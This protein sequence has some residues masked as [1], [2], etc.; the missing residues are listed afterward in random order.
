MAATALQIS[1]VSATG[2]PKMVH[3]KLPK[4]VLSR[5]TVPSPS[6]SVI[7]SIHTFGSPKLDQLIGQN[8]TPLDV[9]NEVISAVKTPQF[10]DSTAMYQPTRIKTVWERLNS[11]ELYELVKHRLTIT[12]D[13]STL[14]GLVQNYQSPTVINPRA[15]FLSPNSTYSLPGVPGIPGMLGSPQQLSPKSPRISNKISVTIHDTVSDVGTQHYLDDF[16]SS[17]LRPPLSVLNSQ[18]GG[19]LTHNAVSSY[20]GGQNKTHTLLGSYSPINP[21]SIIQGS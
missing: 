1:G 15:N 9:F 20:G 14:R 13:L 3:I 21:S 5:T 16:S 2:P 7:D 18:L 8:D 4:S 6:S 12:S 11:A 10:I 17:P 19:S